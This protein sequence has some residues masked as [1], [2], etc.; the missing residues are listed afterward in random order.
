[1]TYRFHESRNGNFGF[2][3]IEIQRS[4]VEYGVL[5]FPTNQRRF[6]PG[7][8]VDFTLNRSGLDPWYKAHVSSKSGNVQVGNIDAGQ[9]ITGRLGEWFRH[10]RI[11]KGDWVRVKQL[12]KHR[13][14]RL[15]KL[16]I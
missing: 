14:Y 4:F 7:Y 11:E 13:E 6:F 3:D 2:L 10:L 8:K 15:Q 9:Y 12:E 16:G 5:C 1:M